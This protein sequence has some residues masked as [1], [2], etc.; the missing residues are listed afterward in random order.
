L[1]QGL[2]V[3]P[4]SPDREGI[5][6][7]E[8]VTN[9]WR[10]RQTRGRC[11]VWWRRRDAVQDAAPP[12]DCQQA[13]CAK[14]NGPRPSTMPPKVAPD[15]DFSFRPA[16]K[17][18]LLLRPLIELLGPLN[19]SALLFPAVRPGK[20]DR[21]VAKQLA[22][23]ACST[24]TD[25]NWLS[26]FPSTVVNRMPPLTISRLSVS[27]YSVRRRTSRKAPTRSPL[28]AN[29]RPHQRVTAASLSTPATPISTRRHSK[30][31]IKARVVPRLPQLIR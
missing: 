2:A 4:N 14:R 5:R 26:G 28:T 21:G 16:G 13:G 6:L 9:C 23:Q 29:T 18:Q 31:S 7:H 1:L 20:D 19:I 27:T 25:S 3:H 12:M 10:N 11:Q 22:K 17:M 24:Q 8:T 15:N 30:N